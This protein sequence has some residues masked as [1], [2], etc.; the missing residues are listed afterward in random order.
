MH[1][2]SHLTSG[3]TCSGICPG[4]KYHSGGSSGLAVGRILGTAEVRLQAM[5]WVGG[6]VMNIGLR[7]PT[8]PLHAAHTQR[9]GHRPDVLCPAPVVHSSPHPCCAHMT[10]AS[11]PASSPS[12]PAGS[13]T[14]PTTALSP[15]SCCCSCRLHSS[16]AGDGQRGVC[17]TRAVEMQSG[18]PITPPV[19]GAP[20]AFKM[21]H[22]R[23]AGCGTEG[24]L[25]TNPPTMRTRQHASPL[26]RHT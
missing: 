12:Q 26:G 1:R 13:S 5:R 11:L 15:S 23:G 22:H 8:L 3:A 6:Q 17:A 18:L 10:S 16:R 20:S 2:L 7:R 4:S 21:E 14:S 24:A 9:T 25:W 19:L